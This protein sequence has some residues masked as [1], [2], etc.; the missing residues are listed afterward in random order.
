MRSICDCNAGATYIALAFVRDAVSAA[1]A[2]A[3]PRRPWWTF[4]S[5]RCTSTSNVLSSSFFSSRRR[6]SRSAIAS[7][8]LSC[9]NST[10]ASFASTRCLRNVRFSATHHDTMFPHI[11]ACMSSSSGARLHTASRTAL[12]TLA[13]LA[14][15]TFAKKGAHVDPVR[16]VTTS[17]CLSSTQYARASAYTARSLMAH[18]DGPYRP[19][20]SDN[21]EVRIAILSEADFLSPLVATSS[22]DSRRSARSE[23]SSSSLSSTTAVPVGG[24]TGSTSIVSPSPAAAIV[25]K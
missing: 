25:A 11:C 21:I 22:T 16:R 24:G 10:D 23:Q 20:G 12:T 13:V 7:E 5:T 6:L 14:F 1:F 4:D 2:L 18:A 15:V 17:S 9:W 8:Y 19:D 3:I